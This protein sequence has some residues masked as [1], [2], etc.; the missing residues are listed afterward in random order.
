MRFEAITVDITSALWDAQ[1]AG[2]DSDTELRTACI[3][4]LGRTDQ[5]QYRPVYHF[6]LILTKGRPGIYIPDLTN[7]KARASRDSMM[8][9]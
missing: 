1:D 7:P 6:G 4:V 3:D 8:G 5:I 9:L 2:Q